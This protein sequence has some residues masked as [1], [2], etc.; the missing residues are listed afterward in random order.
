MANIQLR[1]DSGNGGGTLTLPEPAFPV[2]PPDLEMGVVLVENGSGEFQDYHPYKDRRFFV[3]EWRAGGALTLTQYNNLVTWVA[4][5]RVGLFRY[6]DYDGTNYDD[7]RFMGPR[8]LEGWVQSF[9]EYMG[10]LEFR[11]VV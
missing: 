8:P 10:K 5:N 4:T 3:L 9:H 7:C 1:D 11:Q 2:E 6:T